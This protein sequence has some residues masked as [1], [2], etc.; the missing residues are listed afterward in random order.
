LTVQYLLGLQGLFEVALNEDA[1]VGSFDAGTFDI[2]ADF[3][4]GDPFVNGNFFA[5]AGTRSATYQVTVA[6]ASTPVPEI[7]G[8]LVVTSGVVGLGLCVSLY[9]RLDHNTPLAS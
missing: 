7:P 5:D 2:R 9:R 8:W 1:T 6:P 3:F 4:D